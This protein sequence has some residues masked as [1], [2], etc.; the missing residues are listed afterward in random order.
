G[1]YRLVDALL[2]DRH[3]RS[4]ARRAQTGRG[5]SRSVTLQQDM[6][7]IDLPWKKP[8]NTFV[9]ATMMFLW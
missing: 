5:A 1:E 9:K 6:R 3:P 8:A 2:V 4:L 7:P